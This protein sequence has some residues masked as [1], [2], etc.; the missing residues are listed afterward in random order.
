MDT[1]A[2]ARSSS[3]S[4]VSSRLMR[5]W[6]CPIFFL[7]RSTEA[8]NCSGSAASLAAA[9][10]KKIPRSRPPTSLRT[11]TSRLPDASASRS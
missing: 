4:P 7:S 6:N 8:K 3:I 2:R 9:N 5:T 11:R 10:P 1:D